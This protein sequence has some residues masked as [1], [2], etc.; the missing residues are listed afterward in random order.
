[1]RRALHAGT[2]NPEVVLVEA[3]QAADAAAEQVV[4]IGMS[5][6]TLARYDRPR[7][8]LAATTPCPAAASVHP[9]Q[10]KTVTASI[11]WQAW[12]LQPPSR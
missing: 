6:L 9:N 11:R 2:V 8:R 3:R 1:M 12:S 10:N 5:S 7:R 4:P